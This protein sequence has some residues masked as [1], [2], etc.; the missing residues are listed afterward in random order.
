[1]CC[2]SS[3]KEICK[4]SE[5]SVSANFSSILFPETVPFVLMIVD[6]ATREQCFCELHPGVVGFGMSFQFVYFRF[7]A[8]LWGNR[9]RDK[10]ILL[11]YN[12]RSFGHQQIHIQ[13]FENRK[14]GAERVFLC[15]TSLLIS[16]T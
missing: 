5:Q 12:F 10:I 4:E 6:D 13:P 1:M 11:H 14:T 7:H 15:Y 3:N 8:F 2:R 9:D 16:L